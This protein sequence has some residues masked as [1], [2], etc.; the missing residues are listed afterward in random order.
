MLLTIILFIAVLAVLVLAH[1]LGHYLTA[2][3][4]GCRVEEFG[5]GFPPR[6]W[7][8]RSK[9]TDILYSVNALPLGGF[10]KILGEDGAA[11]DDPTSFAARPAY[12]RVVILVAGVT[13]NVFLAAILLSIG[14]GVGLPTALPDDGS[15]AALGQSA[16]VQDGGIQIS[17]VLPNS[18][19]T[20]AGIQVGD[21]VTGIE[22][23]VMADVS[24]VQSMFSLNADRPLTLTILRQGT[25]QTLTVTPTYL[26]SV[27]SVAV[28]V[29]LV[30]VATVSY[31]W[32][33]AIAHGVLA[34]GHL[35]SAIVMA[36]VTIIAQLIS[37][38]TAG[39]SVSGPVGI[40]VLTGQVARQGF[41]ALLNF[42]AWLSVN[43]AIVNILPLPAL[44][45]GRVLFVILEKLRRRRVDQRLEAIVHNLG[46][47]LILALIVLVT[48]HDVVQWGGGLW[49]KLFG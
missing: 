11:T 45:G 16:R 48:Y 2:R 21:V 32:Y 12:Q 19:A 29:G 26:P 1:E 20:T 38:S 27:G 22:G 8:W 18:P 34:T 39:V 5:F 42:M 33:Q 15:L 36:F 7:G 47:A 6:L 43:L 41:A 23:R 31:P 9:K 28:G 13:M 14:F 44:D 3:W 30:H 24:S 4:F 17:Q 35:I 49:Q 40:A 10:V 25:I 37:G 46:F